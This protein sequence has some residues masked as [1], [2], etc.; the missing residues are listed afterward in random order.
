MV[1]GVYFFPTEDGATI[2]EVATAVEE[3]GFESLFVPEHSH[4]PATKTSMSDAT[5]GVLPERY[6]RIYDPFV[7]LGAA[8]AVTTRIRLGTA[9]CILPIRDIV[10]AAK[11]AATLDR[12]SGG[13]F[14]FGVG[15]G[16]NFE[17]LRTHGVDPETRLERLR[18][19]VKAMKA[20]WIDDQAEFH[21]AFY[22]FPPVWVWPKPLQHP[23]PPIYVAGH[24]PTAVDR[25]LDYGDG[26]LPSH[27]GDYD[28]RKLAADLRTRA[29]ALGKPRPPVTF[30][31]KSAGAEALEHGLECDVDRVL[32][33]IEPSSLAEVEAALDECLAA[34][35]LS[36]G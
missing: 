16:W 3:R 28:M 22:D 20:I 10:L 34:G 9:A 15:S 14:D 25:V 24:G 17:E 31:P 11:A 5:L 35:A 33:P 30:I 2:T 4:F 12:I 6:R 8:A 19:G 23:H 13:R 26:W 27:R 18:E 36:H 29:A 32:M 21:G 1:V 7:A